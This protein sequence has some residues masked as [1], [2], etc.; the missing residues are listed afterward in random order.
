MPEDLK[1]K[2]MLVIKSIPSLV[3]I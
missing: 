1:V 2:F 3:I